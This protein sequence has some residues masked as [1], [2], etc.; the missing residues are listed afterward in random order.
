MS[1]NNAL[2]KI[3][4][5]EYAL[6][7][8]ADIHE[9]LDLRDKAMAYSMLADAKGFKNAAQ[10]AK[11]FQLKSERK[12]GDWLQE[13]VR[14]DGGRPQENTDTLSTLGI[15]NK[16]SQRWQLQAS[17]PEERF[18]DWVDDSLDKG[19]EI[20]ASGLRKLAREVQREERIADDVLSAQ[21]MEDKSDLWELRLG[22][23]ASFDLPE[24]S[25]DAIIVDP[26]YPKEYLDLYESL[27][28]LAAHA[29][30]PGGSLL[31]L[32]GQAH[33]PTVMNIL[34]EYLDYHWLMA[35]HMKGPHMQLYQLKIANIWKP[36]L[37]Y[38]KGKYTGQS[39]RDLVD[40][41]GMEKDR[42]KW[43]QGEGGFAKLVQD[44]TRPG[45]LV[46]DPLC[47]TGTTGVAAVKLGRRFIG[48][49][50]DEDRIASAK[51]RLHD[52]QKKR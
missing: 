5:A 15:H 21:D 8:A 25:V 38:T 18:N 14:H 43:Q 6:Q 36:I 34:S 9:M 2:V 33:L 28:S 24:N 42:F 45:D 16:E 41:G 23:I 19:K 26:P 48:L 11:V 39:V 29:L 3:S 50:I 4:E 20:T 10:K 12:A 51:V 22:D 49:D 13:N 1:E 32:V 35:L 30:K 27:G 52:N 44:F 40:A 46:L 47:G 37:W 31:A 7:A 17:V